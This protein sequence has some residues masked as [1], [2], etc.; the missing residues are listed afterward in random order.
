MFGGPL[1]A[2]YLRS[3]Y[4]SFYGKVWTG[5]WEN[6]VFYAVCGLVGI[7]AIF[8][9]IFGIGLDPETLID[10]IPALTNA[11]GLI[12]LIFLMGYGLVEVFIRINGLGPKRS[13]VQFFKRMVN[14]LY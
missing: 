4:L 13:L 2:G 8:G 1:M 11:Y 10:M 14:D 7:I 6:I 12:L 5:I 3:G 9:A